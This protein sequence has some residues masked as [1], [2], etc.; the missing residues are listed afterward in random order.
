MSLNHGKKYKNIKESLTNKEI[1]NDIKSISSSTTN[2]I[3]KLNDIISKPI[4]KIDT[5][6]SRE[7]IDSNIKN[8]KFQ[9]ICGN[10]FRVNEKGIIKQYNNLLDKS[11]IENIAKNFTDL[12]LYEEI[13]VEYDDKNNSLIKGTNII[14]NQEVENAGK[15]IF[16]NKIIENEN[17]KNAIGCKKIKGETTFESDFTKQNI[18]S[19]EECHKLA[20]DNYYKYFLL[21]KEDDSLNCYLSN[22]NN[23]LNNFENIETTQCEKVNNNLYGLTINNTYSIY[24]VSLGDETNYREGGYIDNDSNF[25]RSNDKLKITNDEKEITT[26]ESRKLEKLDEEFDCNELQND[27]TIIGYVQTK[28]KT[29]C[30]KIDE[31]ILMDTKKRIYDKNYNIIMKNKIYPVENFETIKVSSNKITNYNEISIPT[32]TI[33]DII[34][35]GEPSKEMEDIKELYEKVRETS[36]KVNEELLRYNEMLRNKNT[37]LDTII[38]NEV[39]KQ[40]DLLGTET[41]SEE[42]IEELK[43]KMKEEKLVLNYKYSGYLFFTLG[44]IIALLILFRISKM[45]KE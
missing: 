12:K 9:D 34:D 1:E 44:S 25:I 23:I 16:A 17:I 14:P 3:T 35:R 31:A 26:I 32:F 18:K 45:K 33:R 39:I 10:Y 4:N 27:A 28:D 5:Y 22:E 43:R 7:K 19:F 11:N 41:K 8:K 24:E 13:D 30:Y 2:L 20:I 6:I 42:Y 36:L 29:K 37:N 15:Y 21:Q 38:T 40:R